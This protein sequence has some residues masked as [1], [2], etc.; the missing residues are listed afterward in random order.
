MLSTRTL[1]TALSLNGKRTFTSTS[2]VLADQY[3]CVV[4]GECVCNV[5]GWRVNRNGG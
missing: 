5:G 2:P 1:R 3:D 4:I